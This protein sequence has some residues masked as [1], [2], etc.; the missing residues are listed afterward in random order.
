MTN[1]HHHHYHHHHY[2][3]QPTISWQRRS[4]YALAAYLIGTGMFDTAADGM[5]SPHSLDYIAAGLT[6]AREWLSLG[7]TLCIGGLMPFIA[8]QWKPTPPPRW[9][10]VLLCAAC[11]GASLLWVGEGFVDRQTDLEWLPS[12]Y[13]RYTVESLFFAWL[14]AANYNANKLIEHGLDKHCGNHES[15][16]VPLK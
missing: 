8:A 1:Q 4:L 7:Y 5:F 12:R 9:T 14:V 13:L 6:G 10:V 16:R 3:D 11:V 15:N 2:N